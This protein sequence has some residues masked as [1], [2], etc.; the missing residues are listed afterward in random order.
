MDPAPRVNP[1]KLMLGETKLFFWPTG[2]TAKKN[3]V[4]WSI[5]KIKIILF[6]S[7]GS[8][9]L[10]NLLHSKYIR[11]THNLQFIIIVINASLFWLSIYVCYV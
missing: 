7:Q 5:A 1:N 4:G 9:F 6:D 11:K 3:W 8:Y 10:K 2:R